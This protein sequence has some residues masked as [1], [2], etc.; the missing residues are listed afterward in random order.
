MY[1]FLIYD[2]HSQSSRP[3]KETYDLWPYLGRD[4]FKFQTQQVFM[5]ILPSQWNI[6]ELASSLRLQLADDWLAG[7]LACVRACVVRCS[8][9]SPC[10]LISANSRFNEKKEK[11][12]AHFSSFYSHA[13]V[14]PRDRNPEVNRRILLLLVHVCVWEISFPAPVVLRAI[15]SLFQ[16]YYKIPSRDDDDKMLLLLFGAF[17]GAWFGGFNGRLNPHKTSYVLYLSV[18]LSLFPFRLSLIAFY[19]E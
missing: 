19:F 3:E 5:S 16:G 7:R 1:D 11:T 18:S 15:S 8:S 9:N 10:S 12:Y 2:T 13:K 17:P 4:L 14:A 6:L